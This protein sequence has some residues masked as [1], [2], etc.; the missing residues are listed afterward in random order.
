MFPRKF[1]NA[2]LYVLQQN[3]D[4]SNRFSELYTSKLLKQENAQ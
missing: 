4:H 3:Q 1:D 2:R